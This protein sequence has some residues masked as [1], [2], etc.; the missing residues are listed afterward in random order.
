MSTTR[1]ARDRFE[2]ATFSNRTINSGSSTR[3]MGIDRA[4]RRRCNQGVDRQPTAVHVRD[5]GAHRR[6]DGFAAVGSTRDSEKLEPR[7]RLSRG[8][9][10]Q[11]QES[12][13]GYAVLDFEFAIRI[14]ERKPTAYSALPTLFVG[15]LEPNP[16]R[17]I[18][19]DS[20]ACLCSPLEES[21]FLLPQFFFRSYFE[22]L[23]VPFLYGQAYFSLHQRWPW[24]E[25]SHSAVGLLESYATSHGAEKIETCLAL[26]KR[27]PT[28]WWRIRR[29]SCRG[30]MSKEP[31]RAS[32]GDGAR[33]EGATRPRWMAFSDSGSKSS[34]S[35]F[36]SEK[37]S[38]TSCAY[39][40]PSRVRQGQKGNSLDGPRQQRIS[41]SSRA[42]PP[43]TVY[44]GS[45]TAIPPQDKILT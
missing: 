22:K 8:P 20:S 31:R 37:T 11:H 13:K 9:H 28:H 21:E 6:R 5:G 19:R 1:G 23:V 34:N 16:Q 42:E 10:P 3:R 4:S 45:G 25:Y 14:E 26:L 2:I 18:S 17:H 38:V 44:T 29:R 27:F 36:E 15:G 7:K 33:L 43:A 39:L 32:A 24:S 35:G 30:P 40:Q 12:R 41:R